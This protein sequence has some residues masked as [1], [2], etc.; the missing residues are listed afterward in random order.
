MD[1][2]SKIEELGPWYQSVSFDNIRTNDDNISAEDI[3]LGLRPLIINHLNDMRFLDVGCN[4]GYFTDRFVMDGAELAIGVDKNPRCFPQAL[5][6]KKWLFGED[7]KSEKVI[8]YNESFQDYLKRIPHT[9]RFDCIL[10]SA[11]LYY[12]KDMYEVAKLFSEKTHT[13]ICRWYKVD[14]DYRNGNTFYDH[15]KTFG[16]HENGRSEVGG[17]DFVRYEKD[18]PFRL[19]KNHN[20][21]FGD[22]PLTRGYDEIIKRVTECRNPIVWSRIDA[23]KRKNIDNFISYVLP[24]ELIHRD[25]GP[26]YEVLFSNKAGL[27]ESIKKNGLLNPLVVI[28]ANNGYIVDDG[29]HRA[30]IANLLNLEKVAVIILEKF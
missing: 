12:Q 26:N 7:K 16:F 28:K 14:D 10:A 18:G 19:I 15:L 3:Y 25:F 27:I 20:L 23:E 29:N 30:G 24:R 17:R 1:L 8:F 11:V 22:N 9:T 4:S 13:V 5:F 2:R 6:L 21:L